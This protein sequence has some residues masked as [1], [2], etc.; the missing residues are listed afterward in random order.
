MTVRFVFAVSEKRGLESKIS[1]SSD[2]GAAGNGTRVFQGTRSGPRTF[3]KR[4]YDHGIFTF[5]H[6]KVDQK[7]RFS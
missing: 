6:E 7:E 3:G 5:C 2:V 1:R 4:R